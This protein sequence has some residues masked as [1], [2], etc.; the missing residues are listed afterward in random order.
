[1]HRIIEAHNGTIS[2]SNDLLGGA[3]FE[4]RI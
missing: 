1:V 3:K 2:A 4:I